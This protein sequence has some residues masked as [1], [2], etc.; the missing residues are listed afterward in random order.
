MFDA[1]FAHG[2]PW[3][4]DADVNPD[5]VVVLS[6][7][8]NEKLFGGR[9]SVGERVRLGEQDFEVVGVLAPWRPTPQAYD[10]L[11]NPYG[12]VHEV[13]LPFDQLHNESL[14]L[15][16]ATQ[17]DGFGG[18]PEGDT[19]REIYMAAELN[20]IQF[21]AE[22]SPS[23]VAEYRETVDNYAL[24]QKELGRFPRPLNNRV[25]PL[26]EWLDF[27]LGQGPAPATDALVI[28]SILFL[29]VCSLNLTGLLLAKFLS[30]SGV[31]GIHR[32]LGA[33]KRSI[34][35]QRLVECVL[36]AVAGGMLG[37]LMAGGLLHALDQFVPDRFFRPDTFALDGFTLAVA[38]VF[39]LAAGILSGVYP[40][41]RACRIAP[42]LQLKV[43]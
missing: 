24:S 37:A 21:W 14:G 3:T 18:R 6:H 23:Q 27:Q 13:I 30:R 31:L 38:L 28:V 19:S 7:E 12:N 10:M 41:W 36:V 29:A 15:Q 20:W 22:L 16:R 34:F 43:Q 9:D 11:N 17:S 26:M 35:V 33:P 39:A 5:Q 2:G 42:A 40:A 1:P 4:D 25:Q 8:G 32:A